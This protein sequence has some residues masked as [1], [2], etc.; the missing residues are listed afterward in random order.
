MQPHAFCCK[1]VLPSALHLQEQ[2]R[3]C[4][5]S[6]RLAQSGI[7]DVYLPQHATVLICATALGAHEAGCMAVVDKGVCAMLLGQ[8]N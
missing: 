6:Q 5:P 3:T 1:L 8:C 4:C 2:Q 7:D